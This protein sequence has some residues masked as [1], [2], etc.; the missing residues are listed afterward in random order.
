M[1]LA[2]CPRC[3]QYSGLGEK[4]ARYHDAAHESSTNRS[5]RSSKGDD[6][7]LNLLCPPQSLSTLRMI[8]T[9]AR[10]AKRS[11]LWV[12][13]IRSLYPDV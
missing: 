12:G 8:W 5:S 6:G 2:C 1:G 7:E 9:L 4:P 11:T 3:C 10:A 13:I